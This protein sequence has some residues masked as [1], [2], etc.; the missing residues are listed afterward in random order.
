[1]SEQGVQK[2]AD[3]APL[4][5]PC[6][7]EQRCRCVVTYPYHL[8]VAPQEVHNLVAEVFSPRVL[9]LLM[10]FDCTMVLNSEL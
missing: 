4:K 3:H 6:V 10:S 8:G 1:M 2:G 9:S 5:G 7:E